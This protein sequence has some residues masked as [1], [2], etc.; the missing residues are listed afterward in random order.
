[1]R[2]L[3][4]LWHGNRWACAQAGRQTAYA[5]D[6]TGLTRADM[7]RL[8]EQ[9]TSVSRAAKV[10]RI[11]H[12]DGAAVGLRRCGFE[13]LESRIALSA[14]VHLG[15]VYY[16]PAAGFDAAPNTFT[17][18][19]NGGQPGTQLVELTIDTDKVGDGLTIGDVFF[20]TDSGGL[21]AFGSS[22]LAILSHDGFD[23]MPEPLADG[24]QRLLLRFSGFDPGE[25]LVFTIDVDEQGFL[26]PNAVAEGNEFEG[27]RLFATFAAPHYYD[28][29][30]NDIFLDA[31]DFKLLPT[32]LDLPHDDYVPP[33]SDASPVRTAGAVV[34]L[35]QVPLPISLAGAVFEDMN[36]NNVRDPEDQPLPDVP[37]ALYRLENGDYLPTG[38]TTVT[39]V[40]GNY[41]FDNLMPGRYRVVE[42]QPP[43]YLSV[44]ARAG[45]VSGQTRGVVE[46]PDVIT[47]IDLAGG[48]ESLHN[49]FAEVR[50]ASISGYVYHDADND[51]IRDPDES[52]ISGVEVH[53]QNPFTGATITVWTDSNGLWSAEGLLPGEYRVVEL[54]PAGYLDGQDTPGTL[55]GTA[56]NPGDVLEGIR[57]AG[58]QHGREYNFGE[59]LPGSLSGMV[60]ADRNGDCVPDPDE[61]R[62]SGVT[63]QLLD[64]QGQVIAVTTTDAQGQYHFDN[65]APGT[66][67][68][69]ELQPT[70]YLNGEAHPG[71]VGGA[72]TGTDT[73]TSIQ[74]S[75][76]SNGTGYDFCELEPASISGM[77]IADLNGD[78]AVG[79]GEQP[80]AGVEVQLLDAAGNVLAVTHTNAQGEYRF[81]ALRP[82]V[83]QVRELQP[84]GYFD[85]PEHI[86]SEGGTLLA[87][88]LIANIKL[89]P[90]RRGVHYDFIELPAATI[91]G[92][93]FVDG[94]PI[95]VDDL[96]RDVLRILDN[97]GQWRDGL[98]TPDDTPLAGVRLL[99]ADAAGQLLLDS[100]GQPIVAVTNA[101]GFYQFSPLPPGLYT[102]IQ[103]QPSGY[104][105]GFNIAGTTGGLPLGRNLGNH[106]GA[107]VALG[108][109]DLDLAQLSAAIGGQDAIAR[110]PLAAGQSSTENNFSEV[111]FVGV[112][113]RLVFPPPL[114]PPPPFV[115]PPAPVVPAVLPLPP[116]LVL[117][118]PEPSSNGR[119]GYVRDYTWHLSIIDAGY[120]R[121]ERYGEAT[122]TAGF[123]AAETEASPTLRQGSQSS[124][125]LHEASLVRSLFPRAN[126]SEGPGASGRWTLLPDTPAAPSRRV[127]FGVP[128]GLPVVGDFNGDGV[129]DLGIYVD[130]Q[131]FIDLN[132]N[133]RWDDEDLWAHLGSREDL[134]VTGDWDGDG[135][136][137]IGIFGPVWPADPRAIVHEPGLPAPENQP[138][139]KPKNVPPPPQEATSGWRTLQRTREGDVRADLI[140]H[141]FHY[142]EA[143][144]VPVSGD[145]TGA[146]VDSIGVFRN[147]TWILDSDGDGRLTERDMRLELGRAGDQPVV[148]DFDGDGIDEL[149]VYR[150]GRWYVD[151]NRDR[152]FDDRDLVFEAGGAG[153]LPVVGDW[154]GD[155]VEQPGFYTPADLG[156]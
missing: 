87:N 155:G 26:G 117:P 36:A 28:A 74:L 11:S 65:L 55:G 132:G 96:E 92:Y 64:A 108:I 76:G 51:G 150:N 134:P 77:V 82:G 45:S 120:P 84:A 67:G 129:T 111:L 7:R 122:T 91:S 113:P 23:V 119:G 107:P 57:L 83:Y 60:H 131:W 9:A 15:M 151:V 124:S 137:D 88:D 152:V 104:T 86:G 43:G 73:I 69:R 68:I 4:N 106:S 3:S 94:A 19:F 136:T 110:I 63:I 33:N 128:R 41:L 116:A 101:D 35:T 144:D 114:T 56:L 97:L 39:D 89:L 121:G 143:G 46:S 90:A 100:Q 98:R 93:V 118:V 32:G 148:G 102:V 70:G 80:L 112:T 10:A 24:S 8:S 109:L 146:G 17:L 133:G 127:D 147:G 50:P 53:V 1:M 31:Y 5:H 54:Q 48:E 99:L 21:G 16:E 49:D 12:A 81:D 95:E 139:G 59:L 25:R 85:G 79:P 140:D 52:P 58:G 37:L 125:V 18:T 138:A 29:A 71:S 2:F 14:D 142:G 103:V 126:W 42:T 30:G 47:A 44:G 27:S 38:L 105:S 20:D 34:T 149:G 153:D 66:Y 145:W 130:G 78:S 75:S 22:P 115:P 40:H 62:L 141:V 72:I 135:K 154:S 61:P 6:K 156:L 123:A 13:R